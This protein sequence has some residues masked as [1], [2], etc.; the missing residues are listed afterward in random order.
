[1]HA[2]ASTCGAGGGKE[3]IYH[4][5]LFSNYIS[6]CAKEKHA[7]NNLITMI[8]IMMTRADSRMRPISS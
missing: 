1:M 6:I 2:R 3:G 7:F 5:D 8:I 4:P